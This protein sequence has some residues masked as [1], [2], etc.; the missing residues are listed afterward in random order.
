M[1]LAHFAQA[2]FTVEFDVT[3]PTCYGQPTGSVTANPI[4]GQPPFDYLWNTGATT[5]TISNIPAG[6]YTVTVTDDNSFQ[7]IKN[8]IVE[9]PDLVTV[10]LVA[11]QCELPIIITAT[12]S[13]GIPPYNYAWNIP[14]ESGPVVEAP[15]PGTYCVTMTDQNL[16][17]AVEC[18]TV[19]FDPLDVNV[20]AT[21]VSCPGEDDGA[22]QATPIGGS[23]PYT[24]LWSNGA[25]TASQTGLIP[26]TYVVTVT[27]AAGCTATGQGSVSEPPP[28]TATINSN[29]PLCVG[30]SNGSA[31]VIANGGTP[32]YTYTWSTGQTT[33][34]ISGLSA[35]TYTVTVTDANNCSTAVQTTLS[36]ASNLTA[37]ISVNDESCPDENDGSATVTPLNGVPPYT[38]TWSNGATTQTINNL[39]PGT[40]TVTMT[41]DTGCTTVV[42]EDVAPA[43]PLI[44]SIS[45]TDVTGCDVNDGTATTNIVDGQGPFTF[46]WSN[47]AATQSI[48]NLSE[49]IYAVT[50]TDVNGC[51]ATASVA[52]DAPPAPSM[53][54]SVSESIICFGDSVANAIAVAMGGTMPYEYLWN[55]GETTA[56]IFNLGPGTYICTVTDVN[57]CNAVDSVTITAAPLLELDINGSSV[58]CDPTETG[59]ATVNASGGTPPYTYLWSNGE[60]TQTIDNLT[61]GI[62]SVT[63]TDSQGCTAEGSY[64]ISIID[65]FILDIAVQNVLCKGDSTGSILAEGWGGT[66]PYTYEWSTGETG[67]P[68]IENLPAGNYSVTVTEQN[69]CQIIEDFVVTEPPLL[70]AMVSGSTEICPGDA[71]GSAMAMGMGGTP[72]YSYTWSTGATTQMIFG[73][74]AGTYT[75]TLTD[76]NDCEAVDSITITESPAINLA[77]TGTE[78]VCPPDTLGSATA[79]VSGGTP[80]LS[81]L[82][83]NGETSLTITDLPEGT[84]AITVTDA[85]GC[86]AVDSIS[87]DIIDDFILDIGVQNV[88]CEGDSTGSILAEGWGGTPPYIYEWSTGE[89]GVPMI[90]N[91]PAGNY[92]VTVTD[93]NGCQLMEDFTITE[94]P[95]LI[96]SAVSSSDVCPGEATGVAMAM[97]TGGTP[98]Y[99][100]EWSNGET[101]SV[102]EDLTAGTYFVTVTDDNDCTDTAS[103]TIGEF[104]GVVVVVQGTDIVCGP[105][106]TGTATAV[107][108]AGTPPFSFL[109]STGATT[110]TVT[111]LSEGVVSVTVTDA[112][113]CT[114]TD[115]FTI[116]VIDDLAI[117]GIV[118]DALCFGESTGEITASASG[119]TPPYTY[120]WD[121]GET[122]AMITGLAAGTY[123]V[124]ATDANDCSVSQAFTVSEPPLLMANATADGTVCPGESTGVVMAMGMGG[125]P[126]YTYAWSTG[127]NT[128]T[129]ENLPAGTYTVTVTDTNNCTATADVTIEESEEVSVTIDAPEVVCGAGE[130][131]FAMAEVTGGEPPFF[132]S[133]STGE[134]GA[135]LDQ[136]EDLPEGTYFVTVTD[137]NG[138]T[139][140]EEVTIEVI[141]DFA[142]SVSPRDVLCFGGNSGSILLIPSG[143]SGPYTYNWSTGATT[144]EIINLT[145]GTYSYTVTDA[146]DCEITG[147][148]DISEP[149]LLELN[150][151]TTDIE[152]EGDDNG[153][154]VAEVMGGT[155][156]YTFD[157]NNGEETAVISNL[158]PGTYEVTIT[159]ANFCTTTGTATIT[160][161][162]GIDITLT[163]SDVLCFGESTGG[164]STVVAGG[165]PP[166]EY[167]WNTG[168]TTADLNN[169]PAGTYSLT[170]TDAN[171][172]TATADATVNGPDEFTVSLDIMDIFCD[173]NETGSITANPMGGTPPYT[174][175]WSNTQTGQTITGLGPGDYTVTVT[176]LNECTVV[177]TGTVEFFPGLMLT[178][179]ASSPNCFGES[180]GAAAVTIAG[181]TPPFTYEWDNGATTPELI[182]IPAGVYTVTVTDAVGCKGEETIGIA[183]PPQ[184]IGQVSSTQT[185]DVSCNGDSDGQASVEVNGGTPPYTF[186]WSNGADTQTVTG[187]SAG[188]YDVT[189]TDVNGCT[190]ELSVTIDE[191]DAIVVDITLDN[192][193]TCEDTADGAATASA[194]GGTAPYTFDWSNGDEGASVTGLAAGNYT[195]TVTD[196]NECTATTTVIVDAFPSPSCTIEVVNEVSLAGND[197]ELTINVTGGT[198]PYTYLWDSGQTSQSLSG[199]TAGDYSATVTDANGCQTSCSVTLA[200]PAQIGDFVWNDED[201][202]GIQDPGEDGIEGVMVIL[203]LPGESTPIDIDTTFT[204]ADGMYIFN[205]VP[206]EYKVTFVLPDGLIFADPDQGT[207]DTIDSDPDPTTGMTDV[208]VIGPG[209]T[210]LTIDAGMYTKCDNIDDPG[211]IGPNQFLCGPGNDPDPIVNVES[212][213]GGSGE[214]EYLW[215]KSTIPGPFNIQTWEV[216]PGA[217]GPDFDPGPLSETTYFA[218]CARRECCTVYLESNIVTI[219]V[220]NVAVAEI[221]GPDFLCVGEPT[222]FFA[223]PTGSDAVIEWSFSAGVS[224]Q[225][226]TGPQVSIQV[227][228]LGSYTITLQV[229][230]NGCTSTDVETINATNSPIY[231]GGSMGLVAEVEDEE[232]GLISVNWMVEEFL[233]D[234]TFTLEHSRDGERFEDLAVVEAPSAFLGV[235]NYYEHMHESAKQ[236]RNVYR[237]RIENRAG[238]I[239]YSEEAE[240][241][242]YGDSKIAMLYPN[243]VEDIATL[244][245]FE[246]FGEEATAELINANGAILLRRQADADTKQLQ[247]DLSSLPSGTYFLRLNYSRSGNKVYKLIKR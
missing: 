233:R 182:D 217:T 90:E 128:Q 185:Q 155:P 74:S 68:M 55:T 30:D 236:G 104:D 108:S 232:S 39:A 82:W 156:P 69:G 187:L 222:T 146:N 142:V 54:I 183:E 213:S 230:E 196:A 93:Q 99:S 65:D 211:L 152:C 247:F 43:D 37:S 229:T 162:D 60:T 139:A 131:G 31:T 184:L 76:D 147:S 132:Y 58:I 200:S 49:G 194:S 138:C 124:T 57:G 193:S 224:P 45:S 177:A 48:S 175:E 103:V 205:V 191:P 12:G 135:G 29:N 70:E 201:R 227:N 136:I 1:L 8:V 89:T 218:R 102:I 96:A 84:Y 164:I 140:I 226:A 165:T 4:G 97:G 215:M 151:L 22:V 109:W 51:Q 145:A 17:G 203:Q 101:T 56:E 14:G 144:N 157:W 28:V 95:T 219:E 242:L 153:Q 87:I 24:Y 238:D 111:G 170:V 62:Y 9:E 15:G 212:P 180:T 209:E 214:L 71:N 149:P 66:P 204:D 83:S 32:P 240:A 79:T 105:G 167:E 161:P 67:T 46:A 237:V 154:I 73:L 189:I 21:D 88:L 118:K 120:E 113:G 61:S 216:I 119:G 44:I 199:L 72:P 47:G 117:T 100:Y 26:G 40:Y 127:D 244:E 171:D 64:T 3:E 94:P 52:I 168:A 42:S 98:P 130:T 107:V 36:P 13:G 225:T 23:P 246:T 235:M 134:S 181:G 210:N 77:V 206:G 188:T 178:P 25:T 125:T 115:N 10:D 27:D 80:P 75:V 91:L 38:Y 106:N 208:F 141:D 50:V 19:D 179:I 243:P 166:Y 121:T 174:Y 163:A 150:L 173:E 78:T 114:A 148:E 160:A 122:T 81:I 112:N 198:P 92:S 245:L 169:L 110:Q 116:D 59:S 172:C 11:N 221:N 202:D 35:G 192:G 228:S 176:D 133:W 190:D 197:G 239:F 129:V 85:L 223:G 234:H 6:L 18:I 86:T 5:Q 33:A 53:T 158:S 2:Q 137:A 34:T 123:T 16:C 195:V 159:D 186:D 41:D 231:C 7:V 207:D 220:G 20:T 143:G 126:P 241:I 63:V